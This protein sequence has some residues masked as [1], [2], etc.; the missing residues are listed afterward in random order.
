MHYLP[1]IHLILER[2]SVSFAHV[3]GWFALFQNRWLRY[4]VIIASGFPEDK[5]L[6]TIGLLL[7]S[8]RDN[9]NLL[10]TYLETVDYIFETM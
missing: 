5:A 10:W 1:E 9:S 8:L 6:A 7:N 4:A 3:N 2:A